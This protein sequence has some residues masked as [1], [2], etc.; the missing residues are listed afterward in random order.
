MRFAASGYIGDGRETAVPLRTPPDTGLRIGFGP[1]LGGGSE[2]RITRIASFGSTEATFS[3]AGPDAS[4]VAVVEAEGRSGALGT[5][6]LSF[7]AFEGVF[8]FASAA[9]LLAGAVAGGVTGCD[10]VAAPGE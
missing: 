9:G 2:S 7:L 5:F 4:L 8:T 1:G 3:S 10:A 6:L